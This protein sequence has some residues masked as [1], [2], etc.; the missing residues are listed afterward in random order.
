MALST[1]SAI[2]MQAI[3]VSGVWLDGF[4]TTASPQTSAIMAFQ[5]Q[6]ATGKFEGRDHAK[7]RPAGALLVHAMARTLHCAGSARELTR[8]ADAKSGHVRSSP[9]PRP[10]PRRGILAHLE[11]HE[12]AQCSA[13]AGAARTAICRTTSPRLGAGTMRQVSKA[14]CAAARRAHRSRQRQSARAPRAHHRW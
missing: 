9:A 13:C 8:Q 1:R 11:G 3:A 14:A 5:L 12:L 10:R 6:T 2:F 7:P 4:H